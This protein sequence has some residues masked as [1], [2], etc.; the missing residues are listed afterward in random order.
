VV[1]TQR[2]SV[3]MDFDYQT[4]LDRYNVAFKRKAVSK[5]SRPCMRINHLALLYKTS[6][7]AMVID[8]KPSQVEFYDFNFDSPVT[9][10]GNS[11]N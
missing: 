9:P 8:D 5:R 4:L 6:I 3:V 11:L 1:D 2:L 10:F 7:C